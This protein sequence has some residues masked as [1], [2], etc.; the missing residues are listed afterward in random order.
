MA[1]ILYFTRDSKEA[2]KYMPYLIERAYKFCED[3]DGE[4]EPYELADL[5]RAWF[6][7]GDATKI[8]IW[9]I[10]VDGEIKAH[11]IATT[12]P[13]GMPQLRYVLI[14]QAQ[15]DKG[16]DIRKEC[17]EVFRRVGL[18]TQSMGMSKVLMITH[19][20]EQ[21]MM[22]AWGFQPYK[23]LMKLDLVG[24]EHGNPT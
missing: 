18:W 5:L 2:W 16:I 20:N 23:S 1:E 7:V 21:A 17:K 22:R 11:L 6:M 12:E 4:T 15:V 14:R 8:G 9:A 19:R 3:T 24:S 13:F 10:L